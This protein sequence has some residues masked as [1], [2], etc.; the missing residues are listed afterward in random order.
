MRSFGLSDGGRTVTYVVDNECDVS[1]TFQ[2]SISSMSS[3]V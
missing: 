1:Q 2:K 3:M